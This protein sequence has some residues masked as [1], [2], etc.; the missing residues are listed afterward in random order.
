M[1]TN[2]TYS[3]QKI[4]SKLNNEDFP[5]IGITKLGSF[6]K[7]LGPALYAGIAVH[8]N[9]A[10]RKNLHKLLHVNAADRYR[11]EDPKTDKFLKYFPMQIIASYSRFE[12]DLNRERHRAIYTSPESTWDLK[13]WKCPLTAEE[14][15]I[16]LAKY[17]EF[18]K[19]LD[20]LV[21]YIIQKNNFGILFDLHSYN[22]QREEKLPWYVDQKPVINI[23][24]KS[25]NRSLF[26]DQIVDFLSQLQ[27]ITIQDRKITVAE[28]D[29]F[30]GG[31]VAK[32]LCEKYYNQLIVYAI[33]FKKIFMNEWTGEI[34]QS[35]LDE[36]V[37]KFSQII[38]KSIAEKNFL[39]I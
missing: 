38:E 17:D 22:Y 33:E 14:K 31:Y 4:K 34:Y 1:T 6:I 5:I 8:A 27:T 23:G 11:E 28:N 30:S 39:K 9:S 21:D 20:I 36:I 32:R 26:E 15:K 18:H 35:V 25:I 37:E 24:T 29:I 19:L 16:S 13:V 10:I 12:Y 3:L 7:F 2:K